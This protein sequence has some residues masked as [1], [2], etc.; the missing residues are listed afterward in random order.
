V[1]SRILNVIHYSFL[2][3]DWRHYVLFRRILTRNW[4]DVWHASLCVQVMRKQL[5]K[6]ANCLI[7]WVIPGRSQPK[8]YVIILLHWL[9]VFCYVHVKR[10]C[11]FC[12][13]FSPVFCWCSVSESY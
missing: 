4:C 3:R 9:W 10:A 8:W 13:Q 5:K 6:C 2:Q 1:L 11:L 12:I 7:G